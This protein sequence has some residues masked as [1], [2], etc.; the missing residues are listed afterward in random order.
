MYNSN[1]MNCEKR[2]NEQL[3]IRKLT[4]DDLINF[5]QDEDKNLKIPSRGRKL[6]NYYLNS[7]EDSCK[8]T[9][10]D[11]YGNY[12]ILYLIQILANFTFILNRFKSRR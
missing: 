10:C 12:Y 9:A 6:N 1:K 7:C 8:N 3:N 5:D 2:A 11:S 4:V